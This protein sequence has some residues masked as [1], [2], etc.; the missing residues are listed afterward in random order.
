[1]E[2]IQCKIKLTRILKIECA[3]F[4]MSNMKEDSFY[5]YLF[6]VKGPGLFFILS[7]LINFKNFNVH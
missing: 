5:L 6:F 4:R 3:L 2:A 1:M 7:E